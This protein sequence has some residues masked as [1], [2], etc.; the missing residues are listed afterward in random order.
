MQLLITYLI[1]YLNIFE[2]FSLPILTK[3]QT[4]GSLAAGSGS[5][6][7]ARDGAKRNLGQSE[8]IP[9]GN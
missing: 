5:D 3:A 9:T 6:R 1:T 8:V 7:V 4:Q 2:M